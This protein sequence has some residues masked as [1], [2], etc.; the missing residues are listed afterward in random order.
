MQVML[1]STLI[2]LIPRL[3]KTKAKKQERHREIIYTVSEGRSLSSK[4]G[5]QQRKGK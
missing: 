5:K 2:N 4:Q 3:K 1:R